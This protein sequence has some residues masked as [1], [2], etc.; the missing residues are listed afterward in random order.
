MVA[1]IAWVQNSLNF[2]I[3]VILPFYGHAYE[4]ELQFEKAQEQSRADVLTCWRADPFTD[5]QGWFLQ[6]IT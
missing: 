1:G 5:T 4:R 3:N 2:F 6:A